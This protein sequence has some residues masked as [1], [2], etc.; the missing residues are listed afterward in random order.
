MDT[1][2]ESSGEEELP[3]TSRRGRP[4]RDWTA[5]KRQDF[6]TLPSSAS[7]SYTSSS[8]GLPGKRARSRTTSELTDDKSEFSMQ[9]H[10]V[11]IL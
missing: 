8:Y 3:P 6:D 11:S 4:R 9:N 2:T 7:A 1:A 5:R 10:K